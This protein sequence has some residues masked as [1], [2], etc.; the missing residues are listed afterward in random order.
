MYGNVWEWTRSLWGEDEY[1]VRYK[2]PYDPY[3][4]RENL[5]PGELNLLRVLRGASY[6][7]YRRYA[8]CTTRRS[9]L[10]VLRTSICGFRIALSRFGL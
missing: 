9:P 1:I 7:N 8:R 10:P 2:Y 3:D 5:M 6:N 4:G